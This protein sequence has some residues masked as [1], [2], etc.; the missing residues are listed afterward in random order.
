MRNCGFTPP[1]TA[2][3]RELAI[4][5][6]A[7]DWTAQYEWYAHARLALQAGIGKD[8]VDAIAA[9]RGPR[10]SGRTK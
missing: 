4:I 9:G 5:L 2:R 7:R 3:Q 10:R 1:S 6:T 8:A